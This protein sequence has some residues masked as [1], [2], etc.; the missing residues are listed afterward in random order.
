MKNKNAE[1][2]LIDLTQVRGLA[3]ERNAA[4][5]TAQALHDALAAYLAGQMDRDALDD[6][7]RHAKV[8]MRKGDESL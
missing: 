2:R 7:I 6:A 8:E 4:H 1:C 3:E 5:R